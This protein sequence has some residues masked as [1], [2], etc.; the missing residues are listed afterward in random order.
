MTKMPGPSL[1]DLAFWT[2]PEP[3]R[4]EIRA[5]FLQELQWVNTFF[6]QDTNIDTSFFQSEHCGNLE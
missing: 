4:D 5:L 3:E 2:L 1:L 6:N